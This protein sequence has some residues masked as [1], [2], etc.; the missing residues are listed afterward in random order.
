MRRRL[1][2]LVASIRELSFLAGSRV[3]VAAASLVG[4]E[5]LVFLLDGMLV[6]P[7]LVPIAILALALLWFARERI[8]SR[9]RSRVRRRAAGD[10]DTAETSSR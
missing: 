6:A 9:W 5:A 2:S 4:V 7:E 8:R 10:G 3:W 1:A